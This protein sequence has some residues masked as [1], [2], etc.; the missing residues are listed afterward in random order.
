MPG[1]RRPVAIDDEN[2]TRNLV[3][4]RHVDRVAEQKVRHAM[5]QPREKSPVLQELPDSG[6]ICLVGGIYDVEMGKVGF[7]GETATEEGTT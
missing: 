5:K 7:Y 2:N 1:A 6:A 4:C 3:G